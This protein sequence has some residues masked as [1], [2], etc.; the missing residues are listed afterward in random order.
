[1]TNIESSSSFI[2]SI[3]AIYRDAHF[4][5]ENFQKQSTFHSP[6]FKTFPKTCNVAKAEFDAALQMSKF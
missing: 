1:M 3:V 5:A 6:G 2:H 4:K